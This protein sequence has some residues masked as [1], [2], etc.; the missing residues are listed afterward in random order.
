M[1]RTS[2]AAPV[3][4]S[5]AVVIV[6]LLLVATTTSAVGGG[7]IKLLSASG[8]KPAMV[9]LIPQFEESSGY[10]VTVD[11]GTVGA[12]AGRIQKGEAADV[13]IVSQKQIAT[14]ENQGMV[15]EGST[16]DIARTGVGLF[17]R[18][19]AGKPDIGS[20]EALKRTLLAAPSI[21]H[22]DPARGGGVAIYVARLLDRLDSAGDI[23]P[24]VRLF[25][26]SGYDLVARGEVEIG[27]AGI[28]DILVAPG[29]ELLG[30]LP[31]EVQNYNLMVAGIVTGSAR[32][33]AGKA[34]IEFI[35]SPAAATVLK[36]KGL[37]EPR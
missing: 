18:K 1:M 27:F 25:T 11:Y 21:G 24:K 34:L 31:S 35:S 6:S 5:V 36:A 26:H 2:S 32:Q 23:K 22:G 7:E 13:V 10:K 14:L 9:K 16:M 28:A 15:V 4:A 17:V 20:V 30:P 33:A 19:G 37:F 29:V 8:M 12:L 3:A